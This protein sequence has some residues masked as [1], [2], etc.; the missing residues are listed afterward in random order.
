MSSRYCNGRAI[1]KGTRITVSTVLD[2]LSA[3]DSI[4]EIQ[5]GYPRLSR[6]DILA[7]LAYA[8]HM[9]DTHTTICK[10]A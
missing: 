5:K 2:Y 8:K 9:T 7:C 10:I 1:V 6:E 3:G 4:E